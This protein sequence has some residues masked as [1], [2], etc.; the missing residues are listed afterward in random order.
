MAEC[1][2][3]RSN[4]S[5]ALLGIGVGEEISFLY[6]DALIARVVDRKNQVEFDGERYSVTGLAKKILI[7]QY[8]WSD[9]IHVNGWRYFTKD[10]VTLRN[11]R[12]DLESADVD[13]G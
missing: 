8:G 9:N 7:E 5:F 1:R 11:L 4:N 3:K 10:G 2:T 6:D 13:E 12:D